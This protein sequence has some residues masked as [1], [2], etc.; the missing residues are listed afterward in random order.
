MSE[1]RLEPQFFQQKQKLSAFIA[2]LTS[3]ILS[4][5]KH[6]KAMRRKTSHCLQKRKNFRFLQ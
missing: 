2:L 3:R 4:F 5:L 6:K 1:K